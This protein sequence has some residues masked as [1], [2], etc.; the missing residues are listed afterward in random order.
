[1]VSYRNEHK[2]AYKELFHTNLQLLV[3]SITETNTILTVNETS[4]LSH[5]T[6]RVNLSA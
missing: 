3:M 1:M 4:I 6:Q 2:H 5:K